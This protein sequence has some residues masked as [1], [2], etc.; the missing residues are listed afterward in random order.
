MKTDASTKTD[1]P[2]NFPPEISDMKTFFEALNWA[3]R[4]GLHYEFME[5]FLLDYQR[6]GSVLSAIAFAEREWDL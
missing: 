4:N 6:T 1:V 5:F 3:N 2:E